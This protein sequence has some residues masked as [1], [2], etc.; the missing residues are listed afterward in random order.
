MPTPAAFIMALLTLNARRPL[1]AGMTF[2]AKSAPPMVPRTLCCFRP[3]I[4]AMCSL[5]MSATARPLSFSG[6]Q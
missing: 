5:A 3:P 6:F 1:P 4:A 2:E